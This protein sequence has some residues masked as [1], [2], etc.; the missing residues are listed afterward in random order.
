V[1]SVVGLGWITHVQ[2]LPLEVDSEAFIAA[3]KNS[4]TQPQEITCFYVM[5]EHSAREPELLCLSNRKRRLLQRNE[6]G[7]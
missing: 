7:N 1:E 5:T 2:V 3:A 4:R 6:M